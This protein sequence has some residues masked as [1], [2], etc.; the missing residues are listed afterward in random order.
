MA[1]ER[2][3]HRIVSAILDSALCVYC[4]ALK[5]SATAHK[6]RDVLLNLERLRVTSLA[7]CAECGSRKG[8]T[9][10]L[11]RAH[12]GER[13]DEATEAAV[14]ARKPQTPMNSRGATA[15]SSTPASPPEGLSLP[16]S[17]V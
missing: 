17:A 13:S 4:I 12:P 5:A 16:R 7:Q 14:P 11:G 8:V 6:V 1:D 3:A 2:L 10:S 9:Y 15:A